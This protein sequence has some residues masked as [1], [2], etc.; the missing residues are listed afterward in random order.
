MKVK[1][2]ESIY[3]LNL[4]PKQEG[5]LVQIEIFE[6]MVSNEKK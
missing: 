5:N 3:F 4:H 2:I 6:F 1:K